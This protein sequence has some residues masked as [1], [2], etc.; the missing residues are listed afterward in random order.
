MKIRETWTVLLN[1]SAV[2]VSLVLM[3]AAA[4]T[5]PAKYGAM[6]SSDGTGN[7]GTWVAMAGTGAA[8]SGPAPQPAGL[9]VSSDGT[10]NPG[11]WVAATAASFGSSRIA[12]QKLSSPA[13]TISF[14]S[15]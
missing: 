4:T 11:T 8:Y 3:M 13:G 6:V 1:V 14:T 2:V 7:P 10:G 12:T 15:I 9:M 5:N